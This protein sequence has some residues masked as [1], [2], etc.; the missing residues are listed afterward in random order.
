[1]VVLFLGAL[2]GGGGVCLVIS[3][4]FVQRKG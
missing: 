3:L 1:L 4:V 2:A